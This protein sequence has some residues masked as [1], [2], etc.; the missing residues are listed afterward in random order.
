VN[1]GQWLSFLCLVIVLIFLW[2]IRQVLLLL[3]TAVVLAT[4]LN[5]VVRQLRKLGMPR[6]RAVLLTVSLSMLLAFLFFYLIVP[7]FV[8]QFLQLVALVPQGFIQVVTWVERLFNNRPNWLSEVEFPSPSQLIDEIQP[9]LRAVLPNFFA[10]FSGSLAVVLQTLLLIIFTLML[11]ANPIAYRSVL[12][13]L[14]PSF[15]RR[16]ID[17]IFDRCEIAL[18]SW[19]GG[20]LISSTVV[21]I[22]SAAGLW[23]LQIQFVLAQALLAGLLNFIPNIGPTLSMVFPLTVAA[24][25]APW[26]V[27]AV[28]ILYLVIQN[29]EA[30]LITPTI[31][32]NQVSLL[33]AMTLA[34]QLVF[35]RFFGFLGLLLALP[36]AVIAKTLIQEILIRDILDRWGTPPSHYGYEIEP[37][38]PTELSM[39]PFP[40]L[41][42]L[43]LDEPCDGPPPTS[44]PLE[45]PKV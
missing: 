5:G 16:R 19:L 43:D 14:F 34:A 24:L 45:D 9:L 17:A 23:A 36:L 35:A 27:V 8:D 13:Q 32:A 37:L 41:D 39:N 18:R 26:K 1:L 7:P 38:Q 2:Q 4:A 11:L 40:P 10:I 22:L 25:D 31:M 30:Y 20:A 33:P 12:I 28:I 6:G 21:A 29:L 44:P 42:S 15:Y 3:F